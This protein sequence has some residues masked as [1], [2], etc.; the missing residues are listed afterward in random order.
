MFAGIARTSDVVTYLDGVPYGRFD[1]SG[2]MPH[3]APMMRTRPPGMPMGTDMWVASDSGTGELTLSWVPQPGEWSLVVTNASAR[4]DV[5]AD[6]DLA[7]TAPKLRP[8]AIGVLGGGV[9]V[10]V[11][12]V[13]VIVVAARPRGRRS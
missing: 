10:L 6:I 4:P 1:G 8:I 2:R 9:V 11:T 3:A 12:G 5:R 7:A 13:L